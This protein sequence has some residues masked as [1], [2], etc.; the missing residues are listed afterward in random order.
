MSFTYVTYSVYTGMCVLLNSYNSSDIYIHVHAPA[1]SGKISSGVHINKEGWPHRA[2]AM[3]SGDPVPPGD[4]PCLP[5]FIQRP[6]HPCGVHRA[7]RRGACQG[8]YTCSYTC[9]KMYV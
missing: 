9:T 3:G 4:H 8:T 7:T 5:R 6:D 1:Y 2:V